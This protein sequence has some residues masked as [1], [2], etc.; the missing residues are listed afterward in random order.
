M[1]APIMIQLIASATTK[2]GLKILC[3]EYRKP[4]PQIKIS[5]AEMATLNIKPD[6]FHPGRNYKIEPRN[7]GVK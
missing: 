4:L 2:T 1:A 7:K 5:D 3:K 6:K